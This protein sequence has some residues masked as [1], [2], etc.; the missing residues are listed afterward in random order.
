VI[1]RALPTERVA[2]L[3]ATNRARFWEL[4]IWRP[5]G[6]CWPWCG[7]LDAGRRPVFHNYPWGMLTARRVVWAELR[8]SVA[9]D[10]RVYLSCAGDPTCVNPW[11]AELRRGKAAP[12]GEATRFGA[13]RGYRRPVRGRAP[14][15]TR[16]CRDCPRLIYAV[17]RRCAS[18]ANRER[19]RAQRTTDVR[20][21]E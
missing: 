21:I 9:D 4:V 20:E 5:G 10:Q 7:T 1:E 15:R 18:C 3:E 17:S 2:S 14:R 8:G 11:H 12:G 19:Y 16:V 6:A 13:P